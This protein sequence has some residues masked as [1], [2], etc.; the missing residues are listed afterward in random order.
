MIEHVIHLLLKLINAAVHRLVA[1]D[2]DYVH[3]LSL[4]IGKHRVNQ[5]LSET[6]LRVLID[7]IAAESEVEESVGLAKKIKNANDDVMRG[8]WQATDQLKRELVQDFLQGG[9]DPD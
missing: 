7:K 6:L 9:V 4:F 3:V 5:K 8:V 1:G 2:L